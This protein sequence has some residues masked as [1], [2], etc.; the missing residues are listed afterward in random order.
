MID[1]RVG[2]NEAETVLDDHAAG[3]DSQDRIAL[4]QDKLCQARV[5]A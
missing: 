2:A 3:T 5:L 1:A 4:A